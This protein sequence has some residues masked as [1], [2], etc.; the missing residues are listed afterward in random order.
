MPLCAVGCGDI[1]ENKKTKV[2]ST[3]NKTAAEGSKNAV[4]ARKKSAHPTVR[5]SASEFTSIKIVTKKKDGEKKPFPWTTVF[6]AACFTV[7]FLF[8]MMNYISLDKLSDEVNRQNTVI[9]TLS[10]EKGKLEDKLAKKDNLDEITKYAENELGMVKKDDAK[11]EHYIDINTDDEVK[12]SEYE[13]ET[14]NGIGVLLTGAGNVLK[15]FFG[16]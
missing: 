2:L 9:N 1:M 8:M 5:R 12:I 10:D 15:E 4:I 7:L 6:T 16:G 3:T 11:G 14:E 13:D